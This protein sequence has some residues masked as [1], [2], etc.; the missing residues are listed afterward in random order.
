[1]VDLHHHLLWGLDDGSPDLP[2][3]L[4]MARMAQ[5]D[6]ITHVVVTPHASD[7]YSFDPALV[8]ARRAELADALSQQAIP[9][10]LGL[11][12]DFHLNYDN[13]QDAFQRPR[14]Y[15]VNGTEYLLIELPDYSLPPNLLQTFYDL[16][17]AGMTPILTHPE[18]NPTLQ[19]EPW[20]LTEWIEGG[21]LTQVTAGSI[22][23]AMGRPA[24]RMALD[25]LGKRQVH[26]ISTDAHNLTTRP[27]RMRSAYRAISLRF[28]PAYAEQLC[29]SNPLAVFYGHPLPE[30]DAPLQA[31][32]GERGSEPSW[33]QR[34]F[35][36]RSFS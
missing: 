8:A 10:H 15:T 14:R 16:R 28:S 24:R 26:F 21:L 33:W 6:G 36:F 18:R 25:L 19:K 27:P 29:V 32:P 7:R 3:S 9:L 22:T 13:I 34:W 11:G 5:A 31:P 35:P 4:E 30:Q 17:V 12:C 23:G 1:M 20:R 2:T